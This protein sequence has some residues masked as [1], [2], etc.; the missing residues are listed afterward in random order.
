MPQYLYIQA[1]VDRDAV[2]WNHFEPN[3]IK[4]RHTTVEARD[5][6]EAYT[7]GGRWSDANPPHPDARLFGSA[8]RGYRPDLELINDYVVRVDA[9]GEAASFEADDAAQC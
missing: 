9:A 5:A 7:L 4:F 6:D 3:A 8:A 1:I 2:R